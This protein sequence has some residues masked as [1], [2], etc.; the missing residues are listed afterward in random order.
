MTLLAGLVGAVALVADGVGRM[1]RSGARIG[2]GGGGGGGG[3][4]GGKRGKDLGPLVFILLAVWILSWLMAPVVTRL[5]ALGVSRK[6]EY[7]AD[8]MGAQF[9]RNPLALASALEKIEHA[10]APTTSIKGGAAHLCI[11]DPLG[12][13]TSLREGRLADFFGTH[14]PM[15][16]RVARLKAMGYQ[17]QKRAGTF[18]STVSG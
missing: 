11:C 9:T 15:A 4:R 2:G 17:E 7:L 13:A 16:L 6:R 14:P 12:R 10:D 3:S 1:M 8:A 18:A 5:L